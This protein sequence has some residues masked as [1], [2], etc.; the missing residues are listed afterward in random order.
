MGGTP[1]KTPQGKTPQRQLQVKVPLRADGT[2]PDVSIQRAA[3]GHDSEIW[4][5]GEMRVVL[6]DRPEILLGELKLVYS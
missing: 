2:V 6:K 3:N 4:V 1:P 5:D